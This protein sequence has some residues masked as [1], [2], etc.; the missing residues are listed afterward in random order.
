MNVDLFVDLL[1]IRCSTDQCVSNSD[2]ASH[3]APYISI[4]HEYISLHWLQQISHIKFDNN[5]C[6]I[7]NMIDDM[8]LS[9]SFPSLSL[10]ICEWPVL[11]ILSLI[12]IWRLMATVAHAVQSFELQPEHCLFDKYRYSKC[13]ARNM[14]LRKLY[15]RSRETEANVREYRYHWSHPA[16]YEVTHKSIKSCRC[17]MWENMLEEL[18][19]AVKYGVFLCV[20]YL[21][22]WVSAIYNAKLFKKNKTVELLWSCNLA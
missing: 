1:L 19:F 7:R 3:T 21:S 14:W 16:G 4:L 8:A 17:W 6:Q 5:I 15:K 12:Y 9:N 18:Q 2:G 11:W 20:H 13:M 10:N 22:I